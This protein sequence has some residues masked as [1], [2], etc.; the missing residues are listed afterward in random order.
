MGLEK[1][2]VVR[3]DYHNL[4]IIVH[5]TN[6]I[7][8]DSVIGAGLQEVFLKPKSTMHMIKTADGLKPIICLA[9]LCFISD[10]T[11]KTLND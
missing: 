6:P 7:D 2:P 5:P 1:V 9:P 3:I 8:K 4:N 10:N 11:I